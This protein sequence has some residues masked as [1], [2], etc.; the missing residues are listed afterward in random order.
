[1]IILQTFPSD[2]YRRAQSLFTVA[3]SKACLVIRYKV[4]RA[5]LGRTPSNRWEE[6]IWRGILPVTDDCG[7]HCRFLWRGIRLRKQAVGF[8]FDDGLFS[9]VGIP[10]DAGRDDVLMAIPSNQRKRRALAYS[11]VRRNFDYLQIRTW[12]KKNNLLNST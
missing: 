10:T 2:S 8:L 4:H 1:M 12:H 3:P 5:F 11:Y 7:C 6:R 9:A